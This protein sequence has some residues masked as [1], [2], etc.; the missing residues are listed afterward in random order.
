MATVLKSRKRASAQAKQKGSSVRHLRRKF[1]VSQRIFARL[2][3]VSER[4]LAKFEKKDDYGET[5]RRQVNSLSRLQAALARVIEP[6]AIGE[7]FQQ[8]NAAFGDLKP[9]EVVE[10]GETDRIWAMIYELESGSAS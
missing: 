4:S 1:G 10:R 5:V 7:W 8:P 2:M 3:S 6:E 9:L